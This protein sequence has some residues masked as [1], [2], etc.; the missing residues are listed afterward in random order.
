MLALV[1][2]INLFSYKILNNSLKKRSKILQENTA[3]G[4]KD[5][6]NVSNNI[7]FLKKQY[8]Y[9]IISKTIEKSTNKIYNSLFSI[10]VF[11]QIVSM[12][13][14]YLNSII[15]CIIIVILA[16]NILVGNLSV[17]DLM[18][19]SLV[20]SLYFN[21]ISSFVQTNLNYTMVKEGNS[22]IANEVINERETT[23]DNGIELENISKID[24]RLSH[25]YIKDGVNLHI[26]EAFEIGDVV[27]LHGPSGSGKSSIFKSMLGFYNASQIMY[28]DIDMHQLNIL[29]I[30]KRI[31]YIT[32]T[33]MIF[34]GTI[35]EN[36][37]LNENNIIP[38]TED[39]TIKSLIDEKGL[40][41]K[42]NGNGD[43]LSGG[44][45][46]RINISRE[47]CNPKDIVLCDEICSS[48]DQKSAYEILSRIIK[49]NRD[50]IIFIISHDLSIKELCNKDI[51]IPNGGIQY[52]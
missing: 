5:I 36:L 30:R 23:I 17:I 33:P 12:I 21:E 43:N 27:F 52:E 37:M 47:M 39:I 4:F 15:R 2:P 24:F 14:D 13:I 9:N 44:E 31:T 51:K 35:G 34:S 6:L 25:I 22:F 38:D 7:D 11:A 28:N 41:Y 26:N 29:S 49:N 1:F 50:K 8:D 42:I 3:T 10:N 16:D 32:Q 18:I 20:L 40:D 46:Q 48:L 19:V 45:K